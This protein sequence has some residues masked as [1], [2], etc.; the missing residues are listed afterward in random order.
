MALDQ[1]RA[2]LNQEKIRVQNLLQGMQNVM[3]T[4]N[5]SLTAPPPPPPVAAP[6]SQ[7]KNSTVISSGFPIFC[8]RHFYCSI[9]HLAAL[10]WYDS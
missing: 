6:T 8:I 3:N 10:N 1:E 9:L 7:P 2:T 5:A 4:Y